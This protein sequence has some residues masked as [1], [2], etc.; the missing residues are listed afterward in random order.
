MS[1]L[2]ITML[3]K[4]DFQNVNQQTVFKW[5]IHRNKH[6]KDDQLQWYEPVLLVTP[7]RNGRR[8]PI[9]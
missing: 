1:S 5:L 7:N 8:P 3:C 4:L 2:Q 6:R 9:N